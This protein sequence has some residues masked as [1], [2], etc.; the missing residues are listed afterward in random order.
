MTQVE[1]LEW[2]DFPM[3][4]SVTMT[5]RRQSFRVALAQ[6]APAA[7]PL[8]VLPTYGTDPAPPDP[9]KETER[10]PAPKRPG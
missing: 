10:P 7:L 3:E 8:S 2:T 1:N 6:P 4:E 5:G 9:E